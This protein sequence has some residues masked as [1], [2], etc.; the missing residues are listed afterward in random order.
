MKIGIIVYSQTGNTL[1]VANALKERLEKTHQDVTVEQVI[2][3]GKPTVKGPVQFVNMPDTRGYDV[4]FFGAPVQAF[5][6]AVPMVRYLEQMADL[7]GKKAGCFMTQQFPKPWM[8]GNRGMAVLENLCQQKGGQV[9]AKGIVNW[10]NKDRD[11]L[12]AKVV[13]DLSQVVK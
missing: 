1:H 10:G 13:D 3:D 8:G 7:A 11:A 4:L 12:M 5:T 6:L 2:I 9:F